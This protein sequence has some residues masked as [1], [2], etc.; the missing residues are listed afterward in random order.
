M[1]LTERTIIDQIEVCQDGMIRIRF[2]IQILRDGVVEDNKWHRTVIPQEMNSDLQMQF[3]KDDL[4][5]NK[6]PLFDD[7][8]F[9]RVKAYCNLN[10]L[11]NGVPGIDKARA[12]IEL[13]NEIKRVQENESV[14]VVP[15]G[16]KPSGEGPLV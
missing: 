7:A 5:L 8:E 16:G 6:K 15:T 3:V 1:A 4:T 13:S 2:A 9:S 12:L 11:L 14:Q 10:R